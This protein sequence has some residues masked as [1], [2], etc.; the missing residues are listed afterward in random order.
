MLVPARLGLRNA[1]RL[2]ARRILPHST[3]LLVPLHSASKPRREP[4]HALTFPLRT[5]PVAETWS[6]ALNL[7]GAR[8]LRVSSALG[9]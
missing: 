9:N 8:P 6:Q 2:P 1:G 3:F 4:L 7:A 5:V